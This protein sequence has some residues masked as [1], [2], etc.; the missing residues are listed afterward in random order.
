MQYEP[1]VAGKWLA[2]LKEIAPSLTRVAFVI[3]PKTAPF[4]NYYL[5]AAEPLSQM[6]GVELVPHVC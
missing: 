5:R 3:N 2:M 1:T 6:L 4:F